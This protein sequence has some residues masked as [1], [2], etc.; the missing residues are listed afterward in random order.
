MADHTQREPRR[1]LIIQFRTNNVVVESGISPGICREAV[2]NV[3]TVNFQPSHGRES[4]CPIQAE[5]GCPEYGHLPG[6]GDHV[7]LPAIV[8]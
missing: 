3:R 2:E 4:N 6:W 8:Y 1:E 5:S 7:D